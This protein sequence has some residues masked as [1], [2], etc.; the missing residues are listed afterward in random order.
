[1]QLTRKSEKNVFTTAFNHRLKAD[2]GTSYF[3]LP[4]LLSRSKNHAIRASIHRSE[5][6]L[7]KPDAINNDDSFAI[8]SATTGRYYNF[9]VNVN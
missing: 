7:I 9:S 1:M 8:H 3:S 6:Q 4:L 2:K 5:H